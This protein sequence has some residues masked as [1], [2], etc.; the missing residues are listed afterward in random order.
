L[1]VVGKGGSYPLCW[2]NWCPI[3]RARRGRRDERNAHTLERKEEEPQVSRRRKRAE[4]DPASPKPNPFSSIY[5]DRSRRE[6][7]KCARSKRQKEGDRRA[8]QQGHEFQVPEY[9][10]KP[11]RKRAHH[12]PIAI[13]RR[14]WGEKGKP[15][16]EGRRNGTRLEKWRGRA[17]TSSHKENSGRC[18]AEHLPRESFCWQGERR[19]P[20]TREDKERDNGSPSP[21]FI[22]NSDPTLRSGERIGER[23]GH[24]NRSFKRGRKKS[25]NGKKGREVPGWPEQ[26]PYFFTTRTY[27]PL[28]S[29]AHGG[30]LRSWEGGTGGGWEAGRN[31]RK[32]KEGPG[33]EDPPAAVT[34]RPA[35]LF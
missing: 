15:L 6:M 22:P 20:D 23:K 19:R 21:T 32:E 24:R 30:E 13:A 18:A 4:M 2:D 8:G 31:D 33:C 27:H 7:R 11:F 25:R 9:A 3:A 34:S 12:G 28:K 35:T 14:G 5:F 17:I 10:K 16:K 29:T 1:S 26:T